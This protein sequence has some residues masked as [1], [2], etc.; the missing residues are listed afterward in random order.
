MFSQNR[1]CCN[2]ADLIAFTIGLKNPGTE[3]V[4]TACVLWLEWLWFSMF[5]QQPTGSLGW[6]EILRRRVQAATASTAALLHPATQEGK[7]R[8]KKQSPTQGHAAL[9]H[10]LCCYHGDTET[11]M[12]THACTH[13]HTY[14][15][16]YNLISLNFSVTKGK[17]KENSRVAIN[18]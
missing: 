16:I 10:A 18:T 5:I 7:P 9:T 12:H 4:S 1:V 15:H 17:S 6:V 3:S 13:T 8:K 2:R 14:T 11:Q